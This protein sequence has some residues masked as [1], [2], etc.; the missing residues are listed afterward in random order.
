MAGGV[1]AKVERQRH[2]LTA[3]AQPAGGDLRTHLTTWDD[4]SRYE[5]WRVALDGFEADPL[6]GSGAGTFQRTWERE[7]K[8]HFKVV[9]AH[10]LYFEVLSELGWPGMLF[11]GLALATPFAFALARLR[12]P[13]RHAYAAFIAAGGT[14][15][16]HAGIDWDW[17][18][19]ALFV[20][21]F[22]ASGVA[23]ASRRAASAASP[24]RLTRVVAGLACLGLAVTPALVL[25]SQDALDRSVRAFQ[26]GDC[27][28]A[29]DAA[30]D[31]IDALPARA[32]PF[33]ILGYC[34]ARARRNDLAMR[35]MRSARARDPHGW[36]YAYG[37]AVTQALAGEDPTAAAADAHRL[38]PLEAKAQ[39]LQ[40]AL[41]VRSRAK[42]ARAAGRASIPFD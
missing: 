21:F 16:L 34:D 15:L 13:E 1:P 27:A 20:W 7:R 3:K 14:L 31:S 41:R 2:V 38:N 39:D 4:N 10:S 11:L 42:R 33:E 5:H 22:G 12:G 30:L 17:E 19:P 8:S 18:M 29:I 25:Q 23:L 40:D 32:E 35:A 9:D 6:H 28:T 26:K 36:E 37:L 24:P